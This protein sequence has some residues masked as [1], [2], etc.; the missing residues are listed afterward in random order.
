MTLLAA[1]VVSA[2]DG[3]NS[4]GGGGGEAGALLGAFVVGGVLALGELETRR[5]QAGIDQLGDS[6]A[7]I[8][9]RVFAGPSQFNPANFDVYG[10]VAFPSAPTSANRSRFVMICEAFMQGISPVSE[11]DSAR[12]NL[13]LT[14]WPVQKEITDQQIGFRLTEACTNATD[15]Y[16]AKTSRDVIDAANR[17]G[18]NVD[19]RGPFLIAWSPGAQFTN[20]ARY[21]AFIDMSRVNRPSEAIER[22]REWR[23]LVVSEPET[24]E[25]RWSA[26]RFKQFGDEFYAFVGPLLE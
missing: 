10:V 13:A 24:W 4:D 12:A 6:G 11:T 19:G 1:A 22:I 3:G 23:R 15:L 9:R 14:V 26:G 7:M 5:Q 20:E 2:C 18:Q 16:D 17:S 21:I 8:A 25:Q